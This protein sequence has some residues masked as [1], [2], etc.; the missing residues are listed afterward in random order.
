LLVQDVTPNYIR[1]IDITTPWLFTNYALL[2][3][4]A[5]DTANINAVIKP[6]QWPVGYMRT[7]FITNKDSTSQKLKFYFV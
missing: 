6:F 5:G 7:A 1:Q 2:I 4:V 3:P